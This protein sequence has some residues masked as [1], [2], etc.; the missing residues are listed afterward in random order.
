MDE[1]QNMGMIEN[2]R[3]IAEELLAS[4]SFKDS[5]RLFMKNIDPESGPVLVRTLMGRDVEV[6][7]AV[8]STMPVIANCLI[9]IAMELVAQVRG[10][11]PAPLLAGMAES[12]L[13]DVDRETLACLIR[14][15][16][17]LARDLAPA[18][19]AFSQAVEEQSREGKER[20]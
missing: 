2:R 7:L 19:S 9:K 6:P 20:T 15:I 4:T 17:D 16:R 3:M 10:K 5:L 1:S 13:Q 12:L 18:F 8:M 14:E 11:Y